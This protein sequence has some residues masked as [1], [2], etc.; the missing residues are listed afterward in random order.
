[1]RETKGV[2][3]VV[4]QSAPTSNSTFF[5][6]LLNK[7]FPDHNFIYQKFSKTDLKKKIELQ[8]QPS[9]IIAELKSLTEK[10]ISLFDDLTSKY[11]KS[12]IILILTPSSFQILNRKRKKKLDQTTILLS[13]TKSLDYVVQLPRLIDEVGKKL[14]IKAQNERL[15]KL[16]QKQMP[17][18]NGINELHDV[19]VTK[20]LLGNSEE[21]GLRVKLPQWSKLKKTLSPAALNEVGDRLMRIILDAVR[22]SDQVLRAKENEFV[23]FLKRADEETLLKCEA[24]IKKALQSVDITA[25]AKNVPVP[26]SISQ[27]NA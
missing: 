2:G 14:V 27:L 25:N 24:R 5:K 22:N 26:V 20:D 18:F 11:E 7:K 3:W 10:T 23:I 15:Q 6:S 13:E 4:I 8:A 1:V 12:P 17:W 9:G 21:T 16:I 19:K